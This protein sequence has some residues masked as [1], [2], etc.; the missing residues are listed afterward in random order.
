[1]RAVVA[2][3]VAPLADAYGAPLVAERGVLRA[4]PRYSQ[5]GDARDSLITRRNECGAA[6]GDGA[7]TEVRAEAAGDV[8]EAAA[9]GVLRRA[10]EGGL[11]SVARIARSDGRSQTVPEEEQTA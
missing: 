7:L 1:M 8:G 5:C 6:I 11:R 4:A 9:R 10:A 2:P 3:L